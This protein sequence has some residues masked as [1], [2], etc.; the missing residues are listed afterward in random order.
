MKHT[1]QDWDDVP[2]P[3]MDGIVD[4]S[5]VTSN[6]LQD[7]SAEA[8]DMSRLPGVET[9]TI[10]TTDKRV[11]PVNVDKGTRSVFPMSSSVA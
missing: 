9:A 11:L 6:G 1:K 10:I 4:A 3:S 8:D 5:S 7:V 2:L